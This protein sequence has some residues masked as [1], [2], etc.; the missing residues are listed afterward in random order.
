M[1]D[2]S[3]R[4]LAGHQ[5]ADSARFDSAVFVALGCNDKGSWPDCQSL[6]EGA[7]VRLEDKE[8]SIVARSAWWLSQ[9]WPDPSDPPF[10][11]GVVQVDTKLGPQ[12]LMRVLASIE[13]DMGRFR[14]RLNAPRTLDLDLIAYGRL[15][16]DFDGVILP[17]P[18]AAERLFVMGPLSQIASNWIHPAG[19]TALELASGATVGQD[20]RPIMPGHK[21]RSD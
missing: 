2:F 3:E 6:L 7:L 10:L 11:N 19:G 16:G 18:R 4:P 14:S 15:S 8:V 13:D 12:R 5:L 17:H 1:V 21:H 20:A 9:A